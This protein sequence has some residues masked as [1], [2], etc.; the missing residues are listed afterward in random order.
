MI[1]EN[2]VIKRILIQIIIEAILSIILYKSPN[3]IPR[4]MWLFIFFLVISSL[5]DAYEIY[6]LNYVRTTWIQK[7]KRTLVIVMVLWTFTIF[8]LGVYNLFLRIGNWFDVL[9]PVLL[10]LLV[11]LILF[12]ERM[13]PG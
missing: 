7:Y 12:K 9:A 8:S 13:T 11:P 1:D 5:I 4:E 6:R 10:F 2:V 3:F